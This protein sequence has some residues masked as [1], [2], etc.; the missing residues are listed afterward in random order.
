MQFDNLS[1][2]LAMGGYGLY[3]W[4]A[5]GVSGL[6]MLILWVSTRLQRKN[7][8]QAVVREHQRRARIKA[9]RVSETKEA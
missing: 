7:L 6:A 3:V 9:A 2:F 4:L 8:E 5:F 1:E